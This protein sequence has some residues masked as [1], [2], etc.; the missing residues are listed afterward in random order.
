M[1]VSGIEWKGQDIDC[2]FV[3]SWPNI[4]IWTVMDETSVMLGIRM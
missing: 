4:Q 2:W 1:V 3:C